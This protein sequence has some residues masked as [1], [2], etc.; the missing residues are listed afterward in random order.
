MN[1]ILKNK[2]RGFQW[3][4]MVLAFVLAFS[5]FVAQP[6]RAV[7]IVDTAKC[8]T[9]TLF[10]QTSK[11][12]LQL[13]QDGIEVAFQLVFKVKDVTWQV[14]DLALKSARQVAEGA[15]VALVSAATH[16]PGLTGPRAVA[17]NNYMTQALKIVHV[18]EVNVDS[19]EAAWREDI[20]ALLKAHQAAL[21]AI[22]Q[23]LV[24]TI[25][26]VT[27]AAVENCQKNGIIGLVATITAAISA[28]DLQLAVQSVVLNTQSLLKATA[29]TLKRNA[30][31]ASQLLSFTGQAATLT[32]QL[33]FSLLTGR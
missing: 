9:L 31:F 12:A 32:I 27:A 26:R 5:A 25:N 14:E 7:S 28:A 29:L 20:N 11:S 30:E 24:D 3:T 4:P 22:V 33:T 17:L 16:V 8:A 19:A 10:E 15:F 18:T 1:Q 13:S 21:K 6:V 23:T 2:F